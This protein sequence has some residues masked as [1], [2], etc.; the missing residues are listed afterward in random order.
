RHTEPFFEHYAPTPIQHDGATV[1]VFM[2]SL[3][4][5]VST[6][7]TY[8]PLVGAQIDIPAQSTVRIPLDAEFEYGVLLD[9]GELSGNGHPI[10]VDNLAYFAP[11]S[12]ELT[13]SA[14]ETPVRMLLIGG[15]PLRES[16]VMWWNFIGRSHDEIVEYRA[17]WQAEVIETSSNAGADASSLGRFGHVEG[18]PGAALPAP[19]MPNVR[20]RPRD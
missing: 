9:S 7:T 2:G 15:E 6:A 10:P 19:V 17:R 18:Y 1:H 4:G 5:Q 8:T 11:G 16:I 14:G 3:L 13:L 12:R 20:L